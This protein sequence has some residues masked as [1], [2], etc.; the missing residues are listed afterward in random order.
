MVCVVICFIYAFSNSFLVHIA[1][2]FCRIVIVFWLRMVI[3]FLVHIV[4]VFWVR[5][6]IF[7]VVAHCN[8]FFGCA[9]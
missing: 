7:F 6:I 4:I 1:I 3:I 9:L 8:S 5:R 2:F